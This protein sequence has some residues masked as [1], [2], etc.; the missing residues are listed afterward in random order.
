ME[1]RSRSGA[2]SREPVL[3]GAG[4][5]LLFADKEEE[6]GAA[7]ATCASRSA[8]TE[9]HSR[10]RVPF[11]SI[12]LKGA[13]T[14]NRVPSSSRRPHDVRQRQRRSRDSE[15]RSW[16]ASRPNGSRRPAF[17]S[18]VPL[19]AALTAT[20]RWSTDGLDSSKRLR[21]PAARDLCSGTATLPATYFFRHRAIVV[22][23][24]RT[25]RRVDCGH[26][27]ALG[28]GPREGQSRGARRPAAVTREMAAGRPAAFTV[29]AARLP[30]SRRRVP[31][32]W[33]RSREPVL[34]FH[35]DRIAMESPSWDRTRFQSRT[36]VA[37]A[38]GEPL[39]VR[40]AR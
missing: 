36:H 21:E 19:A 15:T 6:P 5:G 13:Q 3:L 38:M 18:A 7:S 20:F 31:C 34:P 12:M 8:Q 24:A 27:R 25:R 17:R 4:G 2:E 32:G 9:R 30:G 29:D 40:G 14:R 33:R 23:Q 37:L 39:D 28:T 11:C 35:I 22:I 26:H 1:A 16:R 10:D